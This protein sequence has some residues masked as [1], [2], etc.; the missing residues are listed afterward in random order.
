MNAFAP[1][2]ED[3]LRWPLF[4]W[5][6]A[7]GSPGKRLPQIH[8]CEERKKFLVSVPATRCLT[9]IVIF[10]YI[11]SNIVPKMKIQ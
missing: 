2:A 5:P 10:L 6:P 4:W 1:G 3:P 7:R 8:R 9:F 11:Y